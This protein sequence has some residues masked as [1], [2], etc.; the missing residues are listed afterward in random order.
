MDSHNVTLLLEA[1]REAQMIVNKARADRDQILRNSEEDARKAVQQIRA[2]KEEE[3]NRRQQQINDEIKQEI[4]QFA[5]QTQNNLKQFESTIDQKLD[6]VAD[7]L[8]NAVIT[9]N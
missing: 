1:E 4:E 7:I 5:A 2:E 8:V 9:I 6:S 3:L